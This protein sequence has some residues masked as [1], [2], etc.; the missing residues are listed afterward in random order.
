M[1]RCNGVLTEL[2]GG[3]DSELSSETDEASVVVGGIGVVHGSDQFGIT[4]I[5]AV[6]VVNQALLNRRNCRQGFNGG[7][8][9]KDLF[10]SCHRVLE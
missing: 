1:S 9:A 8:W 3:L 6:A 4:S 10:G 2:L 5:N 7:Q